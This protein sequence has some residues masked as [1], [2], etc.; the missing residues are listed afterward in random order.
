MGFSPCILASCREIS[1]F[2]EGNYQMIQIT[3]NRLNVLWNTTI[4]LTAAYN[5]YVYFFFKQI[6]ANYDKLISTCYRY[7]KW[8]II[9]NY[10]DNISI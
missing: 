2:E 9:R 3:V 1:L 4:T 5:L 7:I 8:F 10:V 6:R